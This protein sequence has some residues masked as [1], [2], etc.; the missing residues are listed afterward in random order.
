MQIIAI[1]TD[2][3]VSN[4]LIGESL[5]N[6]PQYLPEGKTIIITD[7]H[8]LKLYG[9]AFPPAPVI[10]IGRGEKYKTLET[11]TLIF[12]RLIEYEADRSTYIVAIGGG[13]VCDVAGFAA[14]VYMRGLPCGFV[15]TTLLSQV[16]ASVGGKNGVNFRGYKNMLGVFRQP[17][18]VI[19][20]MDMLKTLDE[21]EFRSGFAEIV[22]T[23]AIKDAPL[24]EYLERNFEGALKRDPAVMQKLIYDSVMIKARVV[25]TDEKEKGERKKL[26]FG[27]TFAH[28][29]EHLTGMLHGEAVS[30]G[31]VLAA[32]LS[33][34]LGM[35]LKT[36]RERLMQLLRNLELPVDIN[37]NFPELISAMKKD[38]KRQENDLHMILLD[39]IGNA[40]IKTI[41][42]NQMQQYL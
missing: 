18:F 19:A 8:I 40:V 20:D 12:D 13:I 15:S 27:H 7:D 29:I 6:L 41:S 9:K 42:I 37:V 23:A 4:I 16:D 35:L 28:A 36:D 3:K 34:K 32:D 1:K 38:K 21:K 26:N 14:S 2:Q 10:S 24:F 31:M 17:D 22:K 30:I 33:V 25:E 5:R 11:L 39:Q